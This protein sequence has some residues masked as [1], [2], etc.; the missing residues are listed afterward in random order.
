MGRKGRVP[1]ASLDAQLQQLTL[2]SD[3]EGNGE[4]LEQLGPIIKSLDE[5]RQQDEFLRQLRHF[6]RQKDEEIEQ[7]FVS[8]VD[9]LLFVRSGTVNLKHRINELN[10]E[11]QSSGQALIAKKK[12]LI[13]KQRVGQNMDEAMDALQECIQ[14]LEMSALVDELIAQ[15]KYY[16]ALRRLDELGD[17]HLK[18]LMHYEI[19]R[20]MR[21]RI[22]DARE[23][24]RQTVTRQLQGWM[25][26]V[27][28]KS[29]AV[30]RVALETMETRQK[31]WRNRSQKDPMLC[32][33][34]INSPIEQVVN[35]R[36]EVNYLDNDAVT[37][38]FRPLY[39]CIHIYEVLHQREELQRSY[40]EDRKAQA[41]LLLSQHLSL[42]H[43]GRDLV[44][45]LEEVIGYFVVEKHVQHTSPPGF[46]PGT[47]VEDVWES[48]CERVIDM[49]TVG[50][51]DCKDTKAFVEAKAA[52]QTF[53]RTLEGL[54]FN[55]S[56]LNALVL[57]LFRRYAELLRERFAADFQQAIREAQHQ[58][59]IV[60]SPGELDKVLSV[61]WL[62][63]GEAEQLQAQ[64]FPLSLPF[65]QTYPLCC[66]DIR[67]LV[68]QYYNFSTGVTQ[69]HR[70]IDSV[71]TQSLDELL[72]Q[73]I[74]SHIRATV[75]Q[76]HNLSQIAQIIV[77]VEHFQLACTEL[78]IWLANA[79]NPRGGGKLDLDASQHM[80]T[81]LEIAQK[82]ID[83]AL[84]VKLDQ[85]LD[86]REYD[87]TP[88]LQQQTA[89]TQAS[90]YLRDLIDWLSTMMDSALVLLPPAA[91][92]ATYK[93]C[94]MHITSRLLNSALLDEDVR[95][96]NALGLSALEM[97]V[98]YLYH[99]AKAL[100]IDGMDAIF[101]QIRQTLAVIL[102]ESVSEYALSPLARQQKF[103][104]A[105]PVKVASIL[106]KL[107]HY[108]SSQPRSS[109]QASKRL[110]E[111]EMVAR[112]IRR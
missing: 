28:E 79:R 52:V 68:E 45:L 65:S 105:Q 63:P 20:I 70:D 90:G 34:S 26:E 80:A 106:D 110:R 27:R 3:P 60:N 101:G 100:R 94:F 89:P 92:A 62:K 108:Y 38:D 51:R 99:Y 49:V 41:N 37:I 10:Q 16:S 2:L 61:C 78:E 82:R 93:S 9:E 17:V 43:G 107:V 31:R 30:G 55:V 75:E 98:T 6:V 95:M 109:E 84:F 104:Q 81:T 42:Q 19:A 91:K 8:A 11:I 59:M 18:P 46:R 102:S 54:E 48:M 21:D 112:L 56:R 69:H 50:L 5:A 67:N 23:R 24:I 64:P 39:Q 97:D 96:I 85:F 4:S 103:P 76:S 86:L 25:F 73:Q 12:D 36:I 14:V 7:E 88:P 47:E 111:R 66:M 1:H 57:S 72:V 58:P 29:G 40:Q 71:L 32:M 83:T 22:P 35:E 87:W 15:G 13:E 77:N 44:A 33:S 53:I 74:S